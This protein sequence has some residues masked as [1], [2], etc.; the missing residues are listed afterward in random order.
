[1]LIKAAGI[2]KR[3]QNHDN[4]NEELTRKKQLP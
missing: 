3:I 4:K 2:Q 1:M